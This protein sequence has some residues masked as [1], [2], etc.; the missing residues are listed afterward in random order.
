VGRE[1]D[2]VFGVV[3][4]MAMMGAWLGPAGSEVAIA[5]G[6]W[7]ATA[8]AASASA[9]KSCVVFVVRPIIT[10]AGVSLR[11]RAPASL[12]P[13][14][15]RVL[16]PA[17]EL[18]RP[19]GSVLVSSCSTSLL[20]SITGGG[21]MGALGSGDLTS[22]ESRGLPGLSSRPPSRDLSP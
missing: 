20:A 9:A 5:H 17:P 11:G 1:E 21:R 16:G 6:S 15:L 22:P 3:V 7:V 18:A 19:D 12:L 14:S 2:V 8:T 13:G 4:A 10:S